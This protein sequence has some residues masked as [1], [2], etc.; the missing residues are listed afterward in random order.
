M[1]GFSRGGGG[2]EGESV[3]YDG[4]KRRGL[5]NLL[6][7]RGYHLNTTEPQRGGKVNLIVT[8]LKSSYPFH[9][10]LPLVR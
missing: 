2:M 8:Q 3:V 1:K 7:M 10:P 9:P 4:V 6:L 5:V